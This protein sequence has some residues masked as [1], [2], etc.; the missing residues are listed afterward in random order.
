MAQLA[1]GGGLHSFDE[2][3]LAGDL[4]RAHAALFVAEI[5]EEIAGMLV[6]TAVAGESELLA[7]AVD[8]ARRRH[9]LGRALLHTAFETAEKSGATEMFLEVRR[10]NDAAR[11][12]YSVE[13]FEERGVRTRYYSDGEDAV[14][15]RRIIG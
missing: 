4:A 10:S 9:G 7:I 15:M 2:K 12:F 11:S 14:V 5:E 1:L 3:S 13:R 8:P 6:M